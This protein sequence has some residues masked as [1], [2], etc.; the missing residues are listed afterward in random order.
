[1]ESV[2]DRTSSV[3]VFMVPPRNITLEIGKQFVWRLECVSGFLSAKVPMIT[4]A[5]LV[6]VAKNAFSRY[7]VRKPILELM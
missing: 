2:G 4:L 7:H 6:V 5:S 1:M 3:T